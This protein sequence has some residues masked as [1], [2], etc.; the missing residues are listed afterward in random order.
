MAEAAQ[1]SARR[2]YVWGP[3]SL[4]GLTVAVLTGLAD[5]ASKLFLLYVFD[6]ESRVRAPITP[7]IDLVVT[8]NTGI[9]YGLFPQHG[10]SG[11]WAL[12]AVKAVVLVLLWTWLAR[13][14]SRLTAVALGLIVGGAVGNAIDSLHWPGVMDFVLFHVETASFSFRWY[15]FNLADAAI[16][17]GVVGLL[18]DSLWVGSPQKRPDPG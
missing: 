11:V 16:V 4:L 15:V 14:S 10:R 5:Q 1:A 6:L 13:A 9:S 17:A 12:L 2:S 8:W 7:V 18:Y 3:L